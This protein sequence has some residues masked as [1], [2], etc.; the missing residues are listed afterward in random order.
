MDI[1]SKLCS[2]RLR[3]RVAVV[4]EIA[5]SMLRVLILLPI[6]ILEIILGWAER[7]LI[8]NG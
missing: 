1:T 6:R 5:N 8:L 7:M 2:L 4:A 3:G